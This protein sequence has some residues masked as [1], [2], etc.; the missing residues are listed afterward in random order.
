M[1]LLAAFL[2]VVALRPVLR[3]HVAYSKSLYA[4]ENAGVQ[5]AVPA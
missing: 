3:K 4:K 2:A 1:D 5:D